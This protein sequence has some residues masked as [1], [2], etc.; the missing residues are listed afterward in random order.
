MSKRIRRKLVERKVV[1]KLAHLSSWKKHVALQMG[2]TASR[3]ESR[4]ESR[5][6]DVAAINV[7]VEREAI[8][9]NALARKKVDY[10][11]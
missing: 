8:V 5:G 3:R 6:E 2:K 11:I 7:G 10:A 1:S 9:V 4:G